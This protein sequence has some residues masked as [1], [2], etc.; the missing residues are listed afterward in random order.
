LSPSTSGLRRP[1]KWRKQ[2]SG[3]GGSPMPGERVRFRLLRRALA[4]GGGT[5]GAMAVTARAAA[6]DQDDRC[7]L[8]RGPAADYCEGDGPPSGEDGGGSGSSGS[9]LDPLSSLAEGCADAAAWIVNELSELVSST[10]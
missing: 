8:I 6:Q 2:W 7:D 4:V 10:T 1:R 5:I 9:S 3:L